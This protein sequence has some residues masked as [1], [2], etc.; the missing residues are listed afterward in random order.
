MRKFEVTIKF[1]ITKKEV[2]ETLKA[3]FD[4]NF[5]DENGVAKF[6]YTKH[7]N[8]KSTEQTAINGTKQYFRFWKSFSRNYK[9]L[10][11][12]EIG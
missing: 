4:D 12:K 5:V 6:I 1:D 8:C 11:A 10:N 9:I 7:G 3:N 2:V